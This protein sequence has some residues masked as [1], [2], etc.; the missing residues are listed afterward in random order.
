MEVGEQGLFIKIDNV[1]NEQRK[2]SAK[3]VF[4]VSS[5]IM[6]VLLAVV[7]GFMALMFMAVAYM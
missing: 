7:L 3:K 2:K 1:S 4:I 5:V 6:G